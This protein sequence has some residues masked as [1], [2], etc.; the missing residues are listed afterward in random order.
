MAIHAAGNIVRTAF[1]VD[2]FFIQ[3]R[4]IVASE[5]GVGGWVGW[6]ALGTVSICP[7]VVDGERV[8]EVGWFPGRCRMAARALAGKMICRA[9]A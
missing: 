2:V 5:A 9:I 6:V 1:V 4:S 7:L 8:V 3:L